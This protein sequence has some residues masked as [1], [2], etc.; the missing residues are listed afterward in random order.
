MGIHQSRE[1]C[2]PNPDQTAYYS[3]ETNNMIGLKAV[4]TVIPR[5]M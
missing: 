4:K 3:S 5:E 2:N 1:K